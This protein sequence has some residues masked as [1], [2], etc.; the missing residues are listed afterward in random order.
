MLTEHNSSS[1]L[2]IALLLDSLAG[3]GAERVVLELA[4]AFQVL[5]H[6]AEIISLQGRQEYDTPDG[7]NVH[8]VYPQRRVK[9]SRRRLQKQHV[10]RLKSLIDS[11][12]RSHGKF[13]LFLSNLDETNYIVSQCELSPCYFVVHNAILQTLNRAKKMGPFKYWRQ[14][15]WFKALNN[16]KLIAVSDGLKRELASLKWLKPATITRIYNPFDF[17]EIRTRAD[18]PLEAPDNYVIHIGRFSKQKRHD[19]LF[20][21]IHLVDDSTKLVCLGANV[22]AIQKLAVK[23]GVAHRVVT[24]G[25]EQ[26]PYRWIQHAKCLVLSSDFEG[27]GN[28][29]VEALCLGTPVVSTKCQHGPEEI[30]TGDLSVG[31]VPLNDPESLGRAINTAIEQPVVYDPQALLQRFGHLSIASQYLSL[32][33]PSRGE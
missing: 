15:A 27:F 9:L 30:L 22:T 7:V 5:G 33:E 23:K 12:E 2:H 6:R 26:N 21:A 4:K 19:L 20:D 13:D 17:D 28:V 14:K 31:L 10:A 18:E 16:Q 11:L 32:I 29:L 1:Q 25:F 24:P 3:G 8:F